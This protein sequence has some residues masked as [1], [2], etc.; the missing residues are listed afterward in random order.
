MSSLFEKVIPADARVKEWC[1][2]YN[3]LEIYGKFE[4]GSVGIRGRKQK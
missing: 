1:K 2:G 3:K 4:V